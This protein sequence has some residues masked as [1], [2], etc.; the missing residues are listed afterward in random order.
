MAEK[1]PDSR[2]IVSSRHLAE[3]E[4]WELSELE[5]G[6]IIASNAFSRWMTRCM[7][8]A[9][10]PD[11]NPL[12]ILILHNVNHRGKDK[13]LSDICFLLNIEDSHTVNYGL[14]KLLKAGLLASEKRGK[15][16]FYRTSAEGAELCSAYRDVRRQCLLDG[17]SAADL[18]GKD[19][20]ELARSLRALSGH[21]DQ[22]S[23]AAASL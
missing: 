17:L 1:K 23:R 19:L 11:L 14:R 7:A 18:P 20:R 6:L 8:A 15:E 21:Y 9:G 3:G 10:Q 4:G 2:R 5:F 12:E 13:R 16:V 22:A